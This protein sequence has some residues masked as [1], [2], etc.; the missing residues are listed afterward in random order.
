MILVNNAAKSA[1]MQRNGFIWKRAPKKGGPRLLCSRRE[2]DSTRTSFAQKACPLSTRT[3]DQNS[4]LQ[5]AGSGIRTHEGWTPNGY[6]VIS[7][8]L[9]VRDLE[10]VAL[11]TQP[12][13]RKRRKDRICLKPFWKN[14]R[15]AGSWTLPPSGLE[16]RTG[17]L[18]VRRVPR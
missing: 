7:S 16:P 9:L 15:R 14:R 17:P 4:G 11:T 18:V 6:H 1:N 8:L 5:G 13:R 2:R 3:V 12:S 10:A